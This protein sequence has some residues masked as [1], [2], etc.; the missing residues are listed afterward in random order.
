MLSSLILQR[1]TALNL[2]SSRVV[3][4]VCGCAESV[5]SDRYWGHFGTF[6][7]VRLSLGYKSD[8]RRE[9]ELKVFLTVFG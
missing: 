2:L 7:L 9:L 4:D 1:L 5:L 3:C 6:R 8:R